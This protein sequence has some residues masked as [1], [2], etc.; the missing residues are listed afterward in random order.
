MRPDGRTPALASGT[1]GIFAEE[2]ADEGGG[3]RSPR[4]GC[5][6]CRSVPRSFARPGRSAF[7]RPLL[8]GCPGR[9][10]GRSS[11]SRRRCGRDL[12]V[13]RGGP[14]RPAHR[15]GL[16]NG[17]LGGGVPPRRRG[18]TPPVPDRPLS[19]HVAR[20]CGQR[21][22]PRPWLEAPAAASSRASFLIEM[23]GLA[24]EQA[25]RLPLTP[26]H[27]SHARHARRGLEGDAAS[28]GEAIVNG[29]GRSH[30]ERG[31]R[32]RAHRANATSWERVRPALER[33]PAAAAVTAGRTVTAGRAAPTLARSRQ[34]PS[35]RTVQPA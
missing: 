22:W 31:P 28:Q 4:G 19:R 18:S 20:A 32:A 23:D 9:R 15:T 7:A 24:A 13:G 1:G 3:Y 16:S 26:A 29:P 35:G 21:R 34:W 10:R 6:E 27:R 25:K 33:C 2:G 12:S 5:R 30:R 14:G 8:A 11:R 17:V